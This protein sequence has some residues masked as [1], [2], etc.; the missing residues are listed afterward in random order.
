MPRKVEPP[1]PNKVKQKSLVAFFSSPPSGSSNAPQ[2]P[3]RVK[4]TQKRRGRVVNVGPDHNADEYSDGSDGSDVGAVHFE[5]EVIDL[6]D[7]NESPRRPTTRRRTPRLRADTSSPDEKSSEHSGGST[8][9]K[10]SRKRTSIG[11]RKQLLDAGSEDD[12]EEARPK[13]RKFVKGVRPSSPEEDED[14]I[15]DEVDENCKFFVLFDILFVLKYRLGSGIIETRFRTRDKKT[16][17]Q[18]NLERLKSRLVRLINDITCN[19]D[20]EN[21]GKKRGLTLSESSQSAEDNEEEDEDAD[22]VTPFASARPD[23]SDDGS[24]PHDESFQTNE[25][26]SFIVHDDAPAPELPMEYSMG[27]H[28]DLAHHFK[29]ICQL[30][31]HV[32][33]RPEADRRSFMMDALKSM[34]HLDLLFIMI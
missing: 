10:T 22:S 21:L 23:T 13:K 32:A 27:T 4:L 29:I 15:L 1:S 25:D 16:A 26:D 19:F 9:N 33:V 3:K 6:S 12:K 5:Q 31:V 11:K 30:F 34:N 20:F 8:G 17:F 24:S 28:Q 7:E 14:D 18:K 2:T